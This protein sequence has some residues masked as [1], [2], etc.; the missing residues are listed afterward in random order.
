MK[1]ELAEQHTDL[2]TTLREL[3]PQ[4]PKQIKPALIEA[5]QE[6]ERWRNIAR[7]CADQ[8]EEAARLKSGLMDSESRQIEVQR[9]I[10]MTLEQVAARLRA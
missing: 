7:E 1:F 5:A 8:L 4:A 10:R 6:L 3:E 9:Q 2:P